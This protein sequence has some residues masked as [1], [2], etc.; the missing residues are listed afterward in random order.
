MFEHNF[1]DGLTEEKSKDVQQGLLRSGVDRNLVK[2]FIVRSQ[3]C[4]LF[5]TGSV[6]SSNLH[7]HLC[8][9]Q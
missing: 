9:L 7:V 3:A 2:Q 8:T 6:E 1:A 4:S 5:M